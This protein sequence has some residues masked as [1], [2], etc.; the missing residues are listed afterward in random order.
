MRHAPQVRLRDRFTSRELL[1][2][3]THLKSK[4]GAVEERVRLCS[5]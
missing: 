5:A 1:I 2:A 3:T 4:E